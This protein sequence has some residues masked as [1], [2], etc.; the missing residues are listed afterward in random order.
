MRSRTGPERLKILPSFDLLCAH[1]RTFAGPPMKAKM[2]SLAF[3]ASLFSFGCPVRATPFVPP[4]TAAAAGQSIGPAPG[5]V[6]R[7]SAS[8]SAPVV[9]AAN[10]D[11]KIA[12]T[13][14][15]S[16]TEPKN[17][18]ASARASS[19][20]TRVRSR[21]ASQGPALATALP[22]QK[23]GLGARKDQLRSARIKSAAQPTPAPL[24]DSGDLALQIVED[25]SGESAAVQTPTDTTLA[26]VSKPRSLSGT[27]TGTSFRYAK[28]QTFLTE[29]TFTI[30]GS[31]NSVTGTWSSAQGTSGKLDGTIEGSAIRRLH[32]EQYG[33][34]SGTYMGVAI[35]VRERSMLDGSYAGADC[36]G[37]VDGSFVLRAQ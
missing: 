37:E 36:E 35:V 12:A 33:P 11:R 18:S 16:P 19:T 27:F 20:S 1:H 10:D 17:A 24:S 21:H 26:A 6:E 31:G 23:R 28:G 5:S 13:S 34:C 4:I 9:Q 3:C 7:A 15:L 14:N 30:V 29:I 8:P 25:E 32:L 22:R 2:V